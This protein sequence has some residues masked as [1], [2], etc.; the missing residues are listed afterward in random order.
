MAVEKLLEGLHDAGW[1]VF[2][3]LFTEQ[4]VTRAF[5]FKQQRGRR[6]QLAAMPSSHHANQKDRAHHG[7]TARSFGAGKVRGTQLRWFARRMQRVREQE[8]SCDKLR[9]FGGQHAALA[10]A[11]GMAAEKNLSR[12]LSSQ[13]FHG[14]AQAFTIARGHGGKRRA[15]RTRLAKWEIATQDQAA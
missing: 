2:I 13:D 3:G 10:A 9:I 6:N 8:Q 1:K 15:V 11:I 12:R 7:R 4:F 14:P 5:Y